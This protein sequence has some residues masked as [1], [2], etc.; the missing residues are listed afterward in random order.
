[1]HH[2]PRDVPPSL[3]ELLAH[4]HDVDGHPERWQAVAQS[5]HLLEL[6]IAIS[7][8]DEEVEVAVGTGVAAGPRTEQNHARGRTRR[9]GQDAASLRNDLIAYH[10]ETVPQQPEATSPTGAGT[11]TE[12]A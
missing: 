1:M 6:T 8:D 3:H 4:H 12:W 11:A 10:G 5:N 9:L 7:L 2:R